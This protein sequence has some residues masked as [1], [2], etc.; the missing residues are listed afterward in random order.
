MSHCACVTLGAGEVRGMCE[1]GKVRRT[2]PLR[3][4]RSAGGE[5]GGAGLTRSRSR[6]EESATLW[7]CQGDGDTTWRADSSAVGRGSGAVEGAASPPPT[8]SPRPGPASAQ[9]GTSGG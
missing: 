1:C 5:G 8:P 9:G 2:A 6:V 4:R 3:L 7:G